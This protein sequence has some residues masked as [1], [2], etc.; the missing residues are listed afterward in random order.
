MRCC[1]SVVCVV[2][3]NTNLWL[4]TFNIHKNMWL[5]TI[6]TKVCLVTFNRKVWLATFKEAEARV[7]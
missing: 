4:A 7:E 1:V 6:N 3:F 2:A 5:V